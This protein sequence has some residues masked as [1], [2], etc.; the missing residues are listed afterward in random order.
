M[1]AKVNVHYTESGVSPFCS[2]TCLIQGFHIFCPPLLLIEIYFQNT[3]GNL[4]QTK[5]SVINNVLWAISHRE[6]VLKQGLQSLS[7]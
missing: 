1:D 7:L 3:F 2:L 4:I 6:I 5:T